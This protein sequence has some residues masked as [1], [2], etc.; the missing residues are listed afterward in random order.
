[1]RISTPQEQQMVDITELFLGHKEK[2]RNVFIFQAD[3]QVFIY[4]TLGRSEYRKILTDDRFAD[5]EKEDLICQV[6]TLYPEE[7]DFENC[8]AGIP[9]ALTQQI[10]KN[11]YLDGDKARRSVLDHYRGEMWDLDNQITCIINEAFPQF[12]IEEIESWDV[13]KTT[14]YLS[15]AEWKLHNLRGIPFVEPQGDFY[16]DQQEQEGEMQHGNSTVKTEELGGQQETSRKEPGKQK[17]EKSTIRGGNKAEKLTPEKLRQLK[18]QFP[19]I[20]WEGDLG[21]QGIQGLEQDSVDVTSPAL[22][23]GF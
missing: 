20:D 2:H 7:Y 3:N 9:S 18:Q 17:Q 12:D 14:K 23:P 6:C 22:R 8:D 19:D 15:R 5:T 11:S 1:M 4:R 21:N 16:G 10:I 13:E